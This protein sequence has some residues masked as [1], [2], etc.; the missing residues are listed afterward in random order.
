MF[1]EF[2][3]FAVKGS[4]MDLAV[5]I[6]IGSAFN[7]IVS[8]LV[9]DILMPPVGLILHRVDFSNLYINLGGVKYESLKMAQDA[10]A[11]TLNF[12]LFI[13]NLLA[14]LITAFAVFLI[15]KQVNRMKRKEEKEVKQ[16]TFKCPFC[17]SDISLKATR[18]PHCTSALG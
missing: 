8:S 16:D 5:G 4:A 11:P 15:V 3:E 7:K 17:D 1:K 14:F 10:G 13:N 18:C 12:G 6:I 2:K 9:T